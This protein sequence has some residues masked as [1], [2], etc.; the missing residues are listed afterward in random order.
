MSQATVKPQNST[1]PEVRLAKNYRL[2]HDVVQQ[3]GRGRHLSVAEVHDLA[4]T[5]RPGI[6]FTTVYRALGRLRSLGLVSEI[7]LPGADSA[8]YEPAGAPH[9]H[10]RCERCGSVSDVDYMIPKRVIGDLAQKHHAQVT[11]V[12]LTLH[13][14]CANCTNRDA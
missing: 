6:G 1:A 2:V 14:R 4:K 3:Q 5:L 9:A 10:L 7:L 13:G 11:D 12:T 8:Y